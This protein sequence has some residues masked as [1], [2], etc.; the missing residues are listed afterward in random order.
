MDC[1]WSEINKRHA[2]TPRVHM[3]RGMQLGGMRW[4]F[5]SLDSTNIAQNAHGARPHNSAPKMADRLD[6]M[7]CPA[8]FNERAKQPSLLEIST[9]D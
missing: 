2:R 4:P 1:L 6:A 3:L 9:H 7:Q 8:R 5:Y